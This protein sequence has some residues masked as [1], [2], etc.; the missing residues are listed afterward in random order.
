[1]KSNFKAQ[2][3]AFKLIGKHHGNISRVIKNL[4]DLTDS[5][6][7]I[8]KNGKD[9]FEWNRKG[10]TIEICKDEHEQMTFIRIFVEL[11]ILL[12]VT[13]YEPVDVTPESVNQVENKI[14]DFLQQIGIWSLVPSVQWQMNTVQLSKDFYVE[15][16][17]HLLMKII[18]YYVNIKDGRQP[19]KKECLQA[20]Y[21]TSE[22]NSIEFC[23]DGV[24]HTFA[25]W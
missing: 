4:L 5:G 19:Y 6:E 13:S 20:K 23:D 3:D 22:V 12:S 8:R 2:V 9:K 7:L 11:P 18:E 1:M 17:P 24:Y 21:A 14:L 25:R 16:D 15:Y 10:L